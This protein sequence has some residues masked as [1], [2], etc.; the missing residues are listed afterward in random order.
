[1]DGEGCAHSLR[2][3]RGSPPGSNGDAVTSAHLYRLMS[4]LSPAFPVGAYAYS[5]GLEYAVEEGLV[6]DRPGLEEWVRGILLHGSGQ[7]DAVWFRHSWQA[8][9]LGEAARLRE[10]AEA[11]AAFR[12][13]G[14]LAL[15]SRAQ[16]EAFL[17]T[18]S[19]AWD[20]RVPEPLTEPAVPVSYCVAV[21]AVFGAQGIPLEPGL[22]SYLQALAANLVSAGVRLVPLGQSDGQRAA[23]TLE[24][25]VRE[26]VERSRE[27]PL[28]EMGALT[29]MVDWTSMKHETQ[30]T[31]LFRS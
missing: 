31:R 18:V 1:M 20:V 7:M 28:G 16:G 12:G 25:A 15:E 24:A 23:A 8:A 17:L 13:A 6:R 30:R 27:T 9:R 29:P 4:W 26:A 5:H 22:W 14:E 21:G 19:Q 3:A 11:A 10:L 2:P